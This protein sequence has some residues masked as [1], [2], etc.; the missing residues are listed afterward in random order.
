MPTPPS[1]LNKA[2]VIGPIGDKDAPDGAVERLAYEEGIQVF[3]E[4]IHPACTAF[5]L[6]ATRADLIATAG[7]IPEQVFRQLRDCPLVVADLTGANPNV[8][9]ELGLRHTTGKA[10]LQIGEKGRLPFDVAAIRTIMFKRT[11]SGLVQARKDLAKALAAT[12]EAGGDPVTA[13]RVWFEALPANKSESPPASVEMDDQAT[14]ASEELGF[15]EL[16]ADMETGIQSLGQT[17]T[18]AGTIIQN[19]TAIYAEGTNAVRQAEARGGGAAAKLVVAEQV[20][21]RLCD[22]AAKLEVVSGEY[23]QT[24]ARVEPGLRFLL[25]RLV[26]DPQ[27][28]AEVPEFPASIRALCTAAEGSIE[29]TLAMKN[30][31]LKLGNA[32]RSL[33]RAGHRL[34][35]AFARFAAT[36]RQIADWAHLLDKLPDSKS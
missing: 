3:E 10:T 22:Q 25:E 11:A 8:M 7:E 2:F 20:A 15:L 27:Q 1:L 32:S 5:G 33:K 16:L 12:L 28:L 26:E 24:V 30:S 6:Q 36:S 9:Y 34:A 17:A 35:P 21:S 4:V 29:N 13:T 14:E 18:V 23:S 19:I 31:A